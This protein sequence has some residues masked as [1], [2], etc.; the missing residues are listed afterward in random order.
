MEHLAGTRA[1]TVLRVRRNRLGVLPI[2]TKTR[3]TTNGEWARRAG[4][5]R[6]LAKPFQSHDLVA[7]VRELLEQKPAPKK[8]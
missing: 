3:L 6:F 4:A 7:L 8:R 5:D 1:R 2:R